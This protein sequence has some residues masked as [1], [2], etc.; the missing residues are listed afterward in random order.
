MRTRSG[1][2]P[3]ERPTEWTTAVVML[4]LAVL[5]YQTDH[6]TAALLAVAGAVLPV[7]VTAIVTAWDRRTAT[8]PVPPSD[9]GFVRL[10]LI[11]VLALTMLT[12]LLAVVCL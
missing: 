12:V 10:G 11:V 9:G 5:A 6:D 4:V 8:A 3:V 1:I 2:T 7:I